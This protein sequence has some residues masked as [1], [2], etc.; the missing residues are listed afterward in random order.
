[1]F[2]KLNQKYENICFVF[3]HRA[4]VDRIPGLPEPKE[5]GSVHHHGVDDQGRV[6][7]EKDHDLDRQEELGYGCEF[8]VACGKEEHEES[9]G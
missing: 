9:S 5:R 6:H 3:D 2:V 1:M 4:D 7:L 8:G